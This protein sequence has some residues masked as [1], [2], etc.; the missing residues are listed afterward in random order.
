M[1]YND[2]LREFRK[3]RGIPQKQVA[4]LLGISQ[5]HYSLYETGKLVMSADQLRKVCKAY[6]ISAD[7]LLGLK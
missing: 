5:Q 7:Y 3:E 4:G 6:G 2:R 1:K